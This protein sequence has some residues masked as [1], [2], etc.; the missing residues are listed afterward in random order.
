MVQRFRSGGRRLYLLTI[1]DYSLRNAIVDRLPIRV[2]EVL[3]ETE[4]ELEARRRV[5]QR[6]FEALPQ[7]QI[8]LEEWN[9]ADFLPSLPSVSPRVTCVDNVM[10]ARNRAIAP[11][12]AAESDG[13]HAGIPSAAAFRYAL[14]ATMRM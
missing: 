5:P 14:I 1:D 10:Y 2:N 13:N 6:S 9:D 7:S 3:H 4:A 12:F 8:S 11:Q